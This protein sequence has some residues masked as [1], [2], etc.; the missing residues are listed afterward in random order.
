[1]R[2][3]FFTAPVAALVAL[4]LLGAT[5]GGLV[6]ANQPAPHRRSGAGR[7]PARNR[8]SGAGRN[9][10]RN[11]RSGAGR[12]PARPN[13]RSGAGRNPSPQPSFRRRPGPIP[14]HRRSGAGRNPARTNRRS[15][16]GRNP[17]RANRRSGAGRNPARPNRRSGAGRNPGAGWGSHGPLRAAAASAEVAGDRLGG[18]SLPGALEARLPLGAG[19]RG[20][21]GQEAAGRGLHLA[22]RRQDPRGRPPGRPGGPGHGL[23]QVRRRGGGQGRRYEHRRGAGRPA[24]APSR[25]SG[26]SRAAG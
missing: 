16:A 26:R 8:R 17:A 5:V 7:N 24:A 14:P 13:R 22:G 9:P 21:G 20:R 10:A 2:P 19:G 18:E 11:R 3:R 23:D 15:G 4:V 1:M 25:S 6:L 12:D